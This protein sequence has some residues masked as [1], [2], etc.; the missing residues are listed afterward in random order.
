MWRSTPWRGGAGRCLRSH[1][2]PAETARWCGKYLAGSAAQR[3]PAIRSEFDRG[4]RVAA[5]R[6]LVISSGKMSPTRSTRAVEMAQLPLQPVIQL[7]SA[8]LTEP[9]RSDYA[10]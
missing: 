1:G 3:E 7:L 10:V 2:A 6:V 4:P 9:T 8:N 5:A